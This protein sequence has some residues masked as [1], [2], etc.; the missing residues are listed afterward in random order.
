MNPK[1]I[2]WLADMKPSQWCMYGNAYGKECKIEGFKHQVYDDGKT[3]IFDVNQ[4]FTDWL[5]DCFNR[6]HGEKI[7]GEDNG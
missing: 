1:F 7:Q 3:Y 6:E 5:L 2:D 4:E